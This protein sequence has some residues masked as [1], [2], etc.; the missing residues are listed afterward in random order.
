M[1]KNKPKFTTRDTDSQA[2]GNSTNKRDTPEIPGLLN[3]P[4]LGGFLST[5]SSSVNNEYINSIVSNVGSSITGVLSQIGEHPFFQNDTNRGWVL[6]GG[7]IVGTFFLISMLWQFIFSFM[8]SYASVKVILWFLEHYEPDNESDEVVSDHYVSE[9]SAVDVIEYLVVLLFVAALTPLAYFPY[10]GL[11]VN[12]SCVMLSITTLASKDYR[13]KVCRFVKDLLVSSDYEPGKG[14]EG[15]VH[16]SL[17]TFCYTV[18]TLNVGTFNMTHNSRT[19][20]TDL[21]SSTSFTDGLRK[22][23]KKPFDLLKS[24]N[25][26]HKKDDDYP[27]NSNDEFDDLDEEFD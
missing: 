17:Q 21:K 2:S 22:L 23:T 7:S 10:M 8:L 19:V 26:K 5:I 25:A 15:K 11:M 4:M 6:I 9:T 3:N 14:M 24:V 20:V 12:G 1:S 16:S 27:D 13:R 18:E